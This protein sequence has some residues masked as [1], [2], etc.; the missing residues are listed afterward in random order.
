VFQ[1]IFSESEGIFKYYLLIKNKEC[2]VNEGEFLKPACVI[3]TDINSW[4]K[5][6]NKDISGRDAMSQK[7]LIIEGN[8]F[9]FL[10]RYTKIFSCP[11]KYSSFLCLTKMS[12]S[13]KILS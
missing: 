8:M 7:K 10:F 11:D 4:I 1:F 3:K 13:L 12:F 5:I 9:S 2:K 6:G